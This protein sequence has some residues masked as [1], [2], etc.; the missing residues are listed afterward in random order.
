MKT[1]QYFMFIVALL[2]IQIYCSEGTNDDLFEFSM[3]FDIDDFNNI[4]DVTA[5]QIDNQNVQLEDISQLGDVSDDII[6]TVIQ[7]MDADN[8]INLFHLLNTDLTSNKE[9][10]EIMLNIL[11]VTNLNITFLGCNLL[12][13]A[14]MKNDEIAID[15]FLR[16][17]A[18]PNVKNNLGITPLM[19][20]AHTRNI[21][22]ITKLLKSGANPYQQDFHSLNAFDYARGDR[23]VIELLN[24]SQKI[25]PQSIAR[26]NF[27]SNNLLNSSSSDQR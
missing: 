22:I 25:S 14:I 1:L 6:D 10:Y 4:K 27:S 18:D 23:D 12:N 5:Q 26:F 9:K 15:L 3:D 13:Y 7:E 20:A 21:N 2:P 8:I 24:Y 17:G 11:P 16:Y 19:T